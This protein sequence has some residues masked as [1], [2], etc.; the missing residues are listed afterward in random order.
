MVLRLFQMAQIVQ[1]ADDVDGQRF[2]VIMTNVFQLFKLRNLCEVDFW[3][4]DIVIVGEITLNM[5]II[6]YFG[7]MDV[8]EKTW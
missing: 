4:K 3:G 7:T 2:D 5:A 1:S 6:L 8:F